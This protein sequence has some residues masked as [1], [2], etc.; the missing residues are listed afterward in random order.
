M[1][2]LKYDTN[3]PT[4]VNRNR[5]TDIENT[6]VIAKQEGFGGG[7]EWRVGVSRYKLLYIKMDKYQIHRA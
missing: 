2:H 4:F 6:L 1:C 7:M 5:I 3:E